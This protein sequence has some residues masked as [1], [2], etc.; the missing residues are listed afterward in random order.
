MK[1]IRKEI[2]KNVATQ[3]ISKNH[4]TTTLDV[5]NALW[6]EEYWATQSDVSDLMKELAN[7]GVFTF[8]QTG[9][10]R[11]YEMG[12]IPTGDTDVDNH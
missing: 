6:Y 7:E 8:T 3:L 2:V 10:Y 9:P 11:I 5:K 4:T 1:T 12:P